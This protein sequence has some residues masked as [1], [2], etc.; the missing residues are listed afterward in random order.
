MCW[1]SYFVKKKSRLDLVIFLCPI[2]V[3]VDFHPIFVEVQPWFFL[4][5]YK[6][7][8]TVIYAFFLQSH[9]YLNSFF[10]P[11]SSYVLKL[12]PHVIGLDKWFMGISNEP[13]GD[14]LR[15][16]SDKTVA[17]E[18]FWSLVNLQVFNIEPSNLN[19]I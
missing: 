16:R 8:Y 4:T 15:V 10:L 3:F 1:S 12:Y 17:T 5:K 9:Y 19:T 11:V 18:H 14:L 13:L 6:F 7:Q 2:K